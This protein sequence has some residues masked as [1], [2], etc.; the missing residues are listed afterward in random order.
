MDT[1]RSVARRMRPYQ[2]VDGGWLA[3]A[4]DRSYGNYQSRQACIDAINGERRRHGL[5][6]REF[7]PP[8]PEYVLPEPT[9]TYRMDDVPPPGYERGLDDR[10]LAEHVISLAGDEV[11]EEFV[12]E[13]F[14]GAAATL[15]LIPVDELVEGSTDQNVRTPAKER[16]YFRRSPATIP[17]LV[18]EGR[19]VMD[20]GHRLRV[21]RAR[22]V[23]RL[24]C[25]V[26]RWDD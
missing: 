11:D 24:W 22:G 19:T 13:T 5:D 3:G 25:Y 17:P 23:D 14:R 15:E 12:E 4:G 2:N 26:V 18:V 20:G 7:P 9:R 16:R 8:K 21:A 1:T 6:L 10:G